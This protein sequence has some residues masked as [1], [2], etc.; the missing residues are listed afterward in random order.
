MVKSLKHIFW[1]TKM[2]CRLGP[3][4]KQCQ[5]QQQQKQQNCRRIRRMVLEENITHAKYHRG[6]ILI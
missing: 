3:C 1:Q 6:D 5:C 2:F 4:Q